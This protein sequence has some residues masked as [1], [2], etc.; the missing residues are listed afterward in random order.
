MD[1]KIWSWKS[2]PGS[3]REAFQSEI[4]EFVIDGWEPFLM[5]G[6]SDDLVIMFRRTRRKVDKQES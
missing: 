1:Y 3:A 4:R 2:S 5:T 6:N